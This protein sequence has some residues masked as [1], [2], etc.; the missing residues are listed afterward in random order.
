MTEGD[1]E[2]WNVYA[3]SYVS[4]VVFVV[5]SIWFLWTKPGGVYGVGVLVVY[6]ATFAAVRAWRLRRRSR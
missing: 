4:A 6:V 1:D 2:D 3:E 5:G